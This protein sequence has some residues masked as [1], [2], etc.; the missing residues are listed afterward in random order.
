M[1]T[2]KYTNPVDFFNRH[3]DWHHDIFAKEKKLLQ[4]GLYQYFLKSDVKKC[5]FEVLPNEQMCIVRDDNAWKIP[6]GHQMTKFETLQNLIYK[7]NYRAAISQIEMEMFNQDMYYIRVRTDYYRIVEK[8]DRYGVTKKQL[9]PWKEH[10]IKVDHGNEAL[11]QIP[12][13]PDYCLIPNNKNYSQIHNGFYNMYA[14][15]PHKAQKERG[16]LD[17]IPVT[18]DFMHHIFGNQVEL[19]YKYMKCLYEHPDKPMPILC[20]VSK[21]RVTGKTTFLNW[22]QILFGDNFISIDPESLTLQFNAQYATK[23]II[24]LD[25]SFIDKSSGIER[26]KSLSTAKTISVNEKHVSAYTLPFYAKIII[27]SNKEKDFIRVDDEEVRFWVRKLQSLNG[28]PNTGIENDLTRE[29]PA[30]LKIL[31]QMPALDFSRS[32]MLFTKKE[33]ET[34]ELQAIKDESKSTLYKDLSMMFAE[35]FMDTGYKSILVSPKD[36]K[37]RFFPFNQSIG[38][39]YIKKVMQEEFE[40]A[41]LDAQRYYPF[42]P[43]DYTPSIGES[44]TLTRVSTPYIVNA[45]RF[46]VVVKKLE[47]APF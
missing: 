26:L 37:E 9:I 6:E 4:V 47:N 17:D 46:L 31:E 32:R 2:N 11:N 7:G 27:A 22:M 16:L 42:C 38:W 35:H 25:E 34:D 45:Q 44:S 3:A 39:S 5:K 21:E 29:I 19:G 1:T 23:N 40:F 30:F 33:I 10:I 15:F 8:L 13:F 20:L 43:P 24:A 18:H 14:P 28:E 36:V 12:T 41:K